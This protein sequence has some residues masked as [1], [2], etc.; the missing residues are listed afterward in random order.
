MHLPPPP[1]TPPIWDQRSEIDNKHCSKVVVVEGLK[2]S[3]WGLY[4]A[5]TATAK[6]MATE[7]V[8]EE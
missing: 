8:N 4:E 1:T 6:A 7:T 3:E 5:T 2:Q